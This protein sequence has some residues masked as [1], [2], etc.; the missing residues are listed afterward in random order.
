MIFRVDCDAPEHTI[1]A[2]LSQVDRPVAFFLEHY[3]V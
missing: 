3:R 2:T 1:A